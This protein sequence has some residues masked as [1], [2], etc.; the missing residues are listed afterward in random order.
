MCFNLESLDGDQGYPGE[1]DATV[2]YTLNT[3]NELKITY[4]AVVKDR[5]TI[6]NLTCHPYFNL[7]GTE[8]VTACVHDS[9]LPEHLA[10]QGCLAKPGRFSLPALQT[11]PR[12]DKIK[13]IHAFWVSSF[14]IKR[15]LL[16][17]KN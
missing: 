8:K 7:S 14:I 10:E 2:C 9:V 6:V 17:H 1:L 3:D 13:V 12:R 16:S 15:L 5:P 4:K 11:R